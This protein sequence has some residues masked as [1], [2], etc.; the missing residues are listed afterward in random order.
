MKAFGRFGLTVGA[1]VV[2]MGLGSAA[3]AQMGMNG[4]VGL[5]YG[6]FGNGPY[7]NLY[8]AGPVPYFSLYPPVYYSH[9]VPRTY[10]YSPFAYPPGYLTPQI[11]FEQPKVMLNPHVP[12]K[13]ATKPAQRSAPAA[14]RT[15]SV[16]KVIANPFVESSMARSSPAVGRPLV[17]APLLGELVD[18]AGH[19]Q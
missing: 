16:P 11:E 7:N 10:G 2:W 13:S 14:D 15:T 9:P 6:F 17:V 12:Q 8:D 1:A 4:G 5:G 3:H 18:N 19:G